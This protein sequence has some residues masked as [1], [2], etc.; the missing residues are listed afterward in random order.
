MTVTQS[1]CFSLAALDCLRPRAGFRVANR[2][3]RIGTEHDDFGV[4]GKLYL[5]CAGINFDIGS[6]YHAVADGGPVFD[7]WISAS[8][9]PNVR[10][11]ALSPVTRTL[12]TGL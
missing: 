7:S 10:F 12:A 8:L 2:A 5:S 9:N 4:A 3:L 11:S 6:T 1:L